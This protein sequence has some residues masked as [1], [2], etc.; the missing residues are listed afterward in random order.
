MGHQNLIIKPKVLLTI[1]ANKPSGIL[2]YFL[3]AFQKGVSHL[4]RGDHPKK[5]LPKFAIPFLCIK[6]IYQKYNRGYY[7]LLI[8]LQVQKIL[9]AIKNSKCCVQVIK[10]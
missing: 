1:V 9:S 5:H 8:N 4:L 3:A 10:K 6:N 2:D 7:L